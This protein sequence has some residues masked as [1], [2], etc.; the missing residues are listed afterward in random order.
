MTDLVLT[1]VSRVHPTKVVAKAARKAL[2]KRRS[3]LG[4]T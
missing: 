1:G 2:V 3:S 4:A